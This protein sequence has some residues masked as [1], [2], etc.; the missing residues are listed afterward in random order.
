MLLPTLHK[1][2]SRRE[3]VLTKDIRRCWCRPILWCRYAATSN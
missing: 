2:I 3:L 1:T